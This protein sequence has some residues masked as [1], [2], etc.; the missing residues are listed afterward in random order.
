MIGQITINDFLS[1][2]ARLT[3]VDKSHVGK[4]IPFQKLKNY[5]GKKVIIESKTQG[6]NTDVPKSWYKVVII[7]DYCKDADLTYK[8][9]KTTGE[10]VPDFS[11]DKVI[12]SDDK[13]KAHRGN[14]ST[15]EIDCTNGRYKPFGGF[16]KY[17]GC[18]YEYK[19]I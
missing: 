6:Y 12:F 5:I 17:A 9:N 4:I 15:R 11:Y 8:L 7:K 2:N 1:E 10:Y 3:F 13:K 19:A 16:A 14:M 18:F